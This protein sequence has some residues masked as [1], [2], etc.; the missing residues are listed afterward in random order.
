VLR[1]FPV[2]TDVNGNFSVT[3]ITPGTYDVRV[4][5]TRRVSRRALSLILSVGANSRAFGDLLAGDVNGD[6]VVSLVDY[7]RLRASYGR[8]STDTGY[9]AGADFNK[10]G[11][12]TLPDYSRLR[13]NYGLIGPLNAP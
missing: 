6:D 10:D 12:I 2:D 9:Q 5:E 1:T 13:A 8:C 11:C 4:K 3:G 7:S